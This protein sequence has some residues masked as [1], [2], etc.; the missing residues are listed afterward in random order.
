MSEF[1]RG[2]ER[3]ISEGKL[4][5]KQ[6]SILRRSAGNIDPL[7]FGV[8][9]EKR[10]TVGSV[11]LDVAKDAKNAVPEAAREAGTAAHGAAEGAAHI[12]PSMVRD[13]TSIVPHVPAESW[14]D[15][16]AAVGGA[17]KDVYNN[18]LSPA[19]GGAWSHAIR[20][21][22]AATLGQFGRELKGFNP[23][24]KLLTGSA[25]LYAYHRWGRPAVNAAAP[26]AHQFADGVRQTAGQGDGG[27]QGAAGGGTPLYRNPWVYAAGVPL[28]MLGLS[29]MLPGREAKKQNTIEV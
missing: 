12:G 22:G 13:V 23:I 18:V 29:A 20:P 10:A 16:G 17:A 11:L 5:E 14:R 2:F 24:S 21:A 27:G 7:S 3:F 28:G 15:A 1:I 19:M 8:W 4:T 9:Y 6:A 25:A 26:Y